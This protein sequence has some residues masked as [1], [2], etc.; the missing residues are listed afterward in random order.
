MKVSHWSLFGYLV[1]G[2]FA[3]GSF[4]RYYILYPDLDK[5]IAYTT[6]GLLIFGLSWIYNK[7]LN[8]DNTLLALEEYLK[9]D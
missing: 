4:I 9:D 2:T 7:L 8:Q 1:G 5:V 3:I 6:L